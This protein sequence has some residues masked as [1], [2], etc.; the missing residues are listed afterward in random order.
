MLSGLNENHPG[1][2]KFRYNCMRTFE[3]HIGCPAPVSLSTNGYFVHFMP[4]IR[5]CLLKLRP[6]WPTSTLNRSRKKYRHFAFC[7]SIIQDQQYLVNAEM[8][9][10][11]RLLLQSNEDWVCDD[12][13][14]YPLSPPRERSPP[15]AGPIAD[16][17]PE[18]TF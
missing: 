13:L 4:R 10:R 9:C 6:S 5:G 15:P 1:F 8:E 2:V 3:V 12:P 7:V 18:H 14:P 11:S 16:P 17:K